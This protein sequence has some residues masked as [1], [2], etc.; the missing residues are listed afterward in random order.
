MP[1]DSRHLYNLLQG[2]EI[3]G[4]SSYDIWKSIYG[5]SE[6]EFLDFLKSGP[7]G[8]KGDQ[9]EIGPEGPEGPQGV[10]GEKGAQGETGAKGDTGETGK[11]AYQTWQDAGNTGS[12]TDFIASLKGDKGDTGSQGPT[13]ETGERGSVWSSGTGITGTSTTETIFASSGVSSAKVNDYYLN[14]STGY[15]YKCTAA[16]SATEAKWVYVGSIMGPSFNGGTITNELAISKNDPYLKLVNTG[17]GGDTLGVHWYGTETGKNKLGIYDVALA[18]HLLTIEQTNGYATIVGGFKSGGNIQS[19]YGDNNYGIVYAG[20]KA[21]IE[22]N[23]NGGTWSVVSADGSYRWLFDAYN[24]NLAR[25]FRREEST[26]AYKFFYFNNDGT[27]TSAGDVK[28]SSG[29]SLNTVKSS[30]TPKVIATKSNATANT[31]ITFTST[32]AMLLVVVSNN[33]GVATLLIPNVVSDSPYIATAVWSTTTLLR[34][35]FKR[36][37]TGI[38]ITSNWAAG[39]WASMGA[40]VTIYGIG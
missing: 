17:G 9:G 2:S 22:T 1:K 11:S 31:T 5:G 25:L 38:T 26:G 13:G 8:D 34:C 33:N 21:R 27:F 15:V 29:V 40:N 18:R 10:Q 4:E 32:A 6:S 19:I 7:K 23:A 20:N 37:S 30:L 35:T 36:V 3:T 24:N 14:T 12:E 28:T 39:D 16:G